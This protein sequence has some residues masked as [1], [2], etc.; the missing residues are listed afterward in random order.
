MKTT[1]NNPSHQIERL[2]HKRIR[3]EKEAK[4]TLYSTLILLIL[5]ALFLLTKSTDG[6]LQIALN[7]AIV[8]IL[9]IYWEKLVIT[10]IRLV[11]RFSDKPLTK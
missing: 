6:P 9:L 8:L 1:Y 10:L 5:S 4:D 11:A 3:A 7:S 2:E